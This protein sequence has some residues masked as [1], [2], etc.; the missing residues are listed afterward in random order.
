MRDLI[1]AWEIEKVTGLNESGEKA[2]DYI[3]K[4]PD[5]LIRL[6]ERIKPPT[7]H[8]QFSWIHGQ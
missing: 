3:V 6:A 7:L 5:R 1:V 8:Y 4:L 2:R